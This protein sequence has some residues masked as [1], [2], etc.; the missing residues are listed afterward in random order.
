MR[1]NIYES[2]GY[3]RVLAL[4]FSIKQLVLR[5]VNMLVLN[6]TDNIKGEFYCTLSDHQN[7]NVRIIIL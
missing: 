4:Q 2:T 6:E 3:M 1:K 5:D 7:F